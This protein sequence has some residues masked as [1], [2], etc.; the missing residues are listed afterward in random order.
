M[1]NNLWKWIFVVLVVVWSVYEIYPPR[2]RDLAQVFRARAV[3]KDAAF[4]NLWVR[5]V[6]LQRER[7]DRAFG[8]LHDA[9]ATNDITRYFPFFNVKEELRPSTVILNRLH[10]EAAGR[11]KLGLDLQGGTSFMVEM[12]TNRLVRVEVETI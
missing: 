2:G 7:P 3:N 6:Q 4:S 8:N 12:D 9:V 5:V 1:R 10:R 11:I